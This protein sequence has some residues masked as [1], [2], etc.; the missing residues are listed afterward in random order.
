[1]HFCVQFIHIYASYYLRLSVSLRP[2]DQYTRNQVNMLF[3]Q[4]ILKY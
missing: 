4:Q 2:C 3:K 1:M